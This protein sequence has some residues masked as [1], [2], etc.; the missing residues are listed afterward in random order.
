M[1]DK[2]AFREDFF[3]PGI[4]KT[5]GSKR[6]FPLKSGRIVVTDACKGSK[7]WKATVQ[8]TV[9]ATWRGPPLVGP[10][11]LT[12]IFAMPRPKSHYRMGRHAAD[13]KPNAPTYHTKRPDATKML[14]A[15]EDA[16]TG[17]LWRDDAQIAVQTTYKVYDE[18]PGAHISVKELTDADGIPAKDIMA[19]TEM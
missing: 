15:V 10:M 7:D 14:R 9:M 19:R 2:T 3:V 8:A 6:A 4:P 18:R 16:L 13:L 17:V 5:A 11:E 12:I 1:S